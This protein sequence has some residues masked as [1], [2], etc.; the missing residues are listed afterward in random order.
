MARAWDKDG[1]TQDAPFDN[2]FDFEVGSGTNPFPVIESPSH[3]GKR[4][5]GVGLAIRIYAL[6]ERA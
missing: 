5:N 6:V 2:N 4:T 3:V 1:A